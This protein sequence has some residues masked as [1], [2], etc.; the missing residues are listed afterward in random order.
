MNDGPIVVAGGGGFI[1][2][3]LV[4]SLRSQGSAAIRSVDVKPLDQWYQRFE[5]VDNIRLDLQRRPDC[6]AAVAGASE[7]YDVAADMGGMGFI[8]KNKALCRL[9]VRSMRA[10]LPIGA[11]QGW[12]SSSSATG[13]MVLT[14]TCPTPA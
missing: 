13:G 3:H 10:A 11:R 9:S 7:V 14:P 5:D 2:G 4:S 6:E 12:S 1:G 8:E